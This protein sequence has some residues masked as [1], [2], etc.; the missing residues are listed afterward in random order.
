MITEL[1]SRYYGPLPELLLHV[2]YR[3]PAVYVLV[4]LI[5]EPAV[6]Y[7]GV[8][9]PLAVNM[10]QDPNRLGRAQLVSRL[11]PSSLQSESPNSFSPKSV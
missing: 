5:S 11:S 9:K 8:G 7:G 10:M 6:T 1:S 3:Q 4:I 2:S